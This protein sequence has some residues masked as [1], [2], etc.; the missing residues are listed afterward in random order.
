MTAE[1]GEKEAEAADISRSL[2]DEKTR[3]KP[4]NIRRMCFFSVFHG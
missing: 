2:R 4:E 1:E 3:L